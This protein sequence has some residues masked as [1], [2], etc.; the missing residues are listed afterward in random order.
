M[1]CVALA[2]TSRQGRRTEQVGLLF[3]VA[4][5]TSSS[6]QRRIFSNFSGIY[7]IVHSIFVI[8]FRLV[9]YSSSSFYRPYGDLG[10]LMD[11]SIVQ[12]RIN[13]YRAPQLNCI[14]YVKFTSVCMQSRDSTTFTT[15]GHFLSS[16][17]QLTFLLR[18]TDS[19]VYFKV[20]PSLVQAS[21]LQYTLC[22][23]HINYLHL[24]HTLYCT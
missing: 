5:P 20:T 1:S 9:G 23:A 7:W 8:L 3:P 16:S 18:L 12:G 24:S 14:H 21:E 11:S 19:G 6:L 4:P 22:R 10:P 2:Y 13:T 15:S 17:I